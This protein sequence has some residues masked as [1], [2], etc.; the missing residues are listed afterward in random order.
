MQMTQAHM[1]YL[2]IGA[3]MVFGIMQKKRLLLC[4]G[5]RSLGKPGDIHI[6]R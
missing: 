5:F 1:Q 6:D 4:S 2:Y 3:G